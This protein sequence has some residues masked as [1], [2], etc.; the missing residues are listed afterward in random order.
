MSRCYLGVHYPTDVMAG[1]C[2]G[3]FWAFCCLVVARV[4]QRRGKV[5]PSGNAEESLD[6]QIGAK[7]Q[8]Y[9]SRI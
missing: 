3:A 8:G 9:I 5:E 7:D 2:A 6:D 4:L 1:W